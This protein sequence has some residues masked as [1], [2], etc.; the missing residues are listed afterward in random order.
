MRKTFSRILLVLFLVLYA[1]RNVLAAA[2]DGA[3]VIGI[4]PFA[5]I[6]VTGAVLLMA[7]KRGIVF[8]CICLAAACAS[9]VTAVSTAFALAL[10]FH[11]FAGERFPRISKM[12]LGTA[13]L[14]GAEK[15]VF[16]AVKV[17][18]YLETP[19]R[20]AILLRA[21]CVVLLFGA[22]LLIPAENSTPEAGTSVPETENSGDIK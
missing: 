21:A 12:L 16:E 2:A 6:T 3:S 15:Y 22:L 7:G 11:A 1:A 17:W 14:L 19:F 18:Q 4:L 8:G 13:G 9:D 10:L 5:V 20:A